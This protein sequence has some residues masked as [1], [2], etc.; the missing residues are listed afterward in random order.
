M[1]IYNSCQTLNLDYCLMN[2]MIFFKINEKNKLNLFLANQ[3]EN[4]E[5]TFVTHLCVKIRI[6]F[7][8]YNLRA[9]L[10]DKL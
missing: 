7:L 3:P 9:N 8:F 4:K 2:L 6:I 5:R 10:P 1:G